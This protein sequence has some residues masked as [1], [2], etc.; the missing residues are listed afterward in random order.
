M[1][2]KEH[3]YKEKIKTRKE[4]KKITQN[5]KQKR[6]KIIMTAGFFDILHPGHT[7]FLQEAKKLGDI[8]MVAINSDS[9]TRRNKGP[10]RPINSQEI[11]TEVLAALESVDYVTVFNELTPVKI[12][13]QIKPHIWVK[14]GEYKI[15]EMP[16][17][18]IVKRYGGEVKIIKIIGNEEFSVSDLVEKILKEKPYKNLSK[19][20][21]SKSY[22]K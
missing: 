8:L 22:S 2:F 15:E 10:K 19:E 14:G 16:E 12:I 1:N 13:N 7:R 18:P 9:S 6:K 3:N 11:R 21:Y 20:S 4:L 5:L 17:T